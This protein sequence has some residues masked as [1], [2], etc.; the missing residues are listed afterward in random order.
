MPTFN[1][2]GLPQA[3]S[4]NSSTFYPEKVET[5]QPTV[6]GTVSRKERNSSTYPEKVNHSTV[7]SCNGV[8]KIEA[9]IS[10]GL[11]S[12]YLGDDTSMLAWQRHQ[13]DELGRTPRNV[14][15]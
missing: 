13:C 12:H 10:S 7:A 8:Q 6:Q 14:L 11:R 2:D 4:Q 9:T 5:F 1:I 3:K 15:N